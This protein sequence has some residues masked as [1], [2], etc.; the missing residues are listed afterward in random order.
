MAALFF[1]IYNCRFIN[2]ASTRVKW[3][4]FM[5]LVTCSCLKKVRQ[6]S[7]HRY[8]SFFRCSFLSIKCSILSNLNLKQAYCLFDTHLF[9]YFAAKSLYYS[10]P[11]NIHV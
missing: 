2:L 4:L 5:L 8:Q 7:K 3:V 6:P 1:E 10:D 9:T 11:E